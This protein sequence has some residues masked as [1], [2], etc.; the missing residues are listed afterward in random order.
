MACSTGAIQPVHLVCLADGSSV[1][2]KRGK[3]C[4]GSRF[5]RWS[6][7]QIRA[8]LEMLGEP[9]VRGWKVSFCCCQ[10]LRSPFFLLACLLFDSFFL[11]SQPWGSERQEDRCPGPIV[12]LESEFRTRLGVTFFFVARC[13]KLLVLGGRGGKRRRRGG[14]KGGGLLVAACF[15]SSRPLLPRTRER[16][17]DIPF[18]PGYSRSHAFW[19][20]RS[21]C[22]KRTCAFCGKPVLAAL[23]ACNTV[24][25]EQPL[26]TAEDKST[27]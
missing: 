26:S 17:R 10:L 18:P 25:N 4:R 24:Q 7:R 9:D 21:L 8:E 14:R 19:L 12:A 2:A 5:G 15:F 13:P 11:S 23:L 16:E 20:A 22:V 6:R 27:Q 1:W 3:S